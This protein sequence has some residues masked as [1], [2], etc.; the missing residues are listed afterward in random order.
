M[1]PAVLAAP[2]QKRPAA[3]IQVSL[4]ERERLVDPQAGSPQH[5][6]Q[7]AQPATVHAVSGGR[8]TVTISSIVG[9]SAG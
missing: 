9:G 5:D 8:I 6:D 3:R 1:L 4:G 2:R 7:A